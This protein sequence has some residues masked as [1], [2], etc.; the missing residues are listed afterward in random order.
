MKVG[1]YVDGFNL[2]YGGRTL[3]GRG[4]PGWRWLDVRSLAASLI[5]SR[6]AWPAA[7]L[8]RLV[9]CVAR[10]DE[11]ADPLS[12]RSQDVY[13]KALVA[14]G[15][16]DHIEYGHFVSRVKTRPLATSDPTGRPVLTTARWPV[17]VQDSAGSSVRSA[18][19]LV[20]Y[21]DRE[22]KGSDVNIAAHL[23]LDTL[24]RR[25]DAAVLVSNDSDLRLPVQEARRRVPVG[26]VNPSPNYLAGDLRGRT[27]D[28]V[29]GHW[30]LA[31]SATDLL[32]H[33]LP[34]PCCGYSKPKGW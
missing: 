20:S 18:R 31:L 2:Y 16:V 7:V 33:Q 26:L 12:H 10:V 8:D 22:E 32:N 6:T 5:G 9:Y 13:L 17:M 34:D 14:Y 29:G 19:F 28:G 11:T 3:C 25:I 1:V 21:A 15:C 27:T 30:W 24:E 4:A 23:L